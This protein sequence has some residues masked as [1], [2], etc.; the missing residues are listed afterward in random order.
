[1]YL[2]GNGFQNPAAWRND[3][4]PAVELRRLQETYWTPQNFAGERRFELNGVD[5]A[6]WDHSWAVRNLGLKYT[7][8]TFGSGNTYYRVLPQSK[9]P[10][11]AFIFAGV[12]SEIIGDYGTH[13]AGAAGDEFDKLDYGAGTPRHA[14]HLAKSEGTPIPVWADAALAERMRVDYAEKNYASII[15]FETPSG[16]AVFSVGSMAYIGALNHN[17]FDNDVARIT[18]NVLRRFSDPAPFKA[19]V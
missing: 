8:T 13:F 12:N 19:P 6:E 18:T 11:A 5:N 4:I 10:R 15:F 17:G 2:G 1:M 16:G 7:G 9:D 3:G 14:L